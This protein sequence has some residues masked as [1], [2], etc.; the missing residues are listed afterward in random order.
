MAVKHD[1]A[2]VVSAASVAAA[3]PVFGEFAIIVLAALFGS[4]VALSRDKRGGERRRY[5][6]ANFIFRGVC[7]ASFT[8]GAAASWLSGVSG[9]ELYR[10]LAPA[11]FLIAVV[12]DDWFTVKDWVLERL[13]KRPKG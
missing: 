3:S 8:S 9:V 13:A 11:A 10:L 1:S 12:G 5:H 2:A 7:I 4:L 6:A